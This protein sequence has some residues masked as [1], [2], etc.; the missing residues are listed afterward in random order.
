MCPKNVKRTIFIGSF[1][2]T[3]SSTI[4]PK[5]E[6]ASWKWRQRQPTV[7]VGQPLPPKARTLLIVVGRYR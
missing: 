4:R 5:N 3:H 7:D 1:S 2:R 6:K